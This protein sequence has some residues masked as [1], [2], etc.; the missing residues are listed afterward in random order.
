[1]CI[2]D[3]Y[4]EK[5]NVPKDF[6]EEDLSNFKMYLVYRFHMDMTN[7]KKDDLKGK[8]RDTFT[9][10]EVYKE[11]MNSNLYKEVL[12]WILLNGLGKKLSKKDKKKAKAAMI[13]AG[14]PDETPKENHKKIVY[15]KRQS[16]LAAFVNKAIDKVTDVMLDISIKA[17]DW[18]A[19]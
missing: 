10:L 8:D 14:I 12:N 11:Y 4:I 2:R 5:C 15:Y 16:R 18:L 7:T 17:N 3:S 9:K 13:N 6:K 1:M 19:N